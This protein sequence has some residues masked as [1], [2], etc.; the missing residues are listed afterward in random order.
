MTRTKK[1]KKLNNTQGWRW[2]I[3]TQGLLIISLS[4]KEPFIE[5]TDGFEDTW[6]YS[7]RVPFCL[8]ACVYL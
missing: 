2:G 3:G 1:E 5:P 7:V 8:C 6:S 4:S